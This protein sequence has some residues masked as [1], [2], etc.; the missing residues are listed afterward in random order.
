MHALFKWYFDLGV[1]FGNVYNGNVQVEDNTH[2]PLP[3][4]LRKYKRYNISG[5]K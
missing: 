3:P 2:W 1:A 5:I 4:F